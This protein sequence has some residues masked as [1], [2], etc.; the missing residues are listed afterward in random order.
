MVFRYNGVY[1][2]QSLHFLGE[3]LLGEPGVMVASIM[4][5][6]MPMI[7]IVIVWTIFKNRPH[8][9]TLL[10]VIVSFIGAMLVITKGDIKAFLGRRNILFLLCSYSFPLLDGL[11]TRWVVIV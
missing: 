9:F 1:G 11:Y 10:C 5:S 8:L 7:S 3:D 2:L 6:L 4:E